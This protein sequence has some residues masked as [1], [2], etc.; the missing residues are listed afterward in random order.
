M[1]RAVR[2]I[3]WWVAVVVGC[4]LLCPVE[5][6]AEKALLRLR[7]D[8]PVLEAPDDTAGLFALLAQ[9]E[10]KTLHYWVKT[11]H[12][13]AGDPDVQGLVLIIEEPELGLAQVEELTAAV[14]AFRA[15]GKPV[16]CYLDQA[17][18]LTYALAASADYITLADY[19]ELEIIGLR[20]EMMFFKGLLDKIGVEA[21]MMHCGAYK[22]ALEPF[23]RTEPSPEA[24]ENINWLLDSLFDRWVQ[25]IAEGRKLPVEQV[26]K[27]VDAAPLSAAQALEGKLVDEV[28]SFPAF[29]QKLHKEFGPDVKVLKEYEEGE[30]LAIDWQNP[31]A[32][33]QFLGKMMEGEAPAA[34]PG[35]GLIYIEGSIMVGKSDDNPFGVTTAGSTT[36]RSAFEQARGDDSIRAVVV[37]V[38]S[39]GGSA[40]ASDIIW[41][42]ATR[43]AAQKPVIVSMGNVAGSGGYYVSIPGDTVFAEATT[44]TGSIG[45]VGGKLILKKLLEEKLGITTTEFVRGQHAGLMSLNRKW[46]EA[47]RTWMTQYM[48]S[49]YEQF[50]SRVMKSRGDRIKKSLEEVA[51]GRVYTG[52]QAVEL[53]LVD[54][55]GGLSDA[56]DL[57]AKKASLGRDYE[58]R[59]LPK[60]SGFAE[61]LSFLQKLM[62]KEGEDE[63][64]I[65]MGPSL[66]N[67]P[68]L[69]AALPLV[70]DLAPAQ[71]R[72]LVRD[73]YN[74]VILQRERVGCFMPLVPQVR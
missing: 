41:E 17:G 70:R 22:S 57:A 43:C 67:D 14:K 24:A 45:V 9:K 6:R 71:L 27:L 36:L 44:I 26:K 58:V 42:A 38:D 20:G 55:L 10:A 52:A 63:F 1:A 13:A 12:R 56:L 47:E 35:V 11:L 74:L 25:L 3:A 68:L 33:F 48:N 66:R 5:A 60:P 28:S 50:K 18:N 19:S 30:G 62:G 72:Q 73:L 31:F 51:G 2:G 23:T 65:G 4:A 32:F 69:R 34:Q 46:T 21:D 8:G 53:G 64:E 40:L 61:F 29:K 37:R 49:V 7:L 39:P 59:L 15:K 16:Y 54:K